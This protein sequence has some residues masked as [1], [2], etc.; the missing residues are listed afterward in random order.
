MPASQPAYFHLQEFS[1]GGVLL[2][3][4]RLY[5]YAQGTTALKT[6]YTDPAGAV[7]QTYTADGLGG[8]YIALNARGE[9]PA[10]LYLA[11]GSYDIALKRPDGSTVWTR[12]A[13]PTVD[14]AALSSD[15]GTA[16]ISGTWFGNVVASLA[17]LGTLLGASLIGFIQAGIGAVLRSCQSKLRERI[18]VADFGA[19]GDGVADDTIAINAALV[20]AKGK[21]LEFGA[22]LTYK[23]TSSLL[24]AGSNTGIDGKGATIDST[25]TGA[26]FDNILTNG[27]GY[28]NNIRMRDLYIN[29]RTAGAFG[30]KVRNSYSIYERVGFALTLTNTSG[31]GF[32]LMGDPLGAGP[33][34]NKFSGCDVQS[35]S[36]GLDHIGVAFMQDPVTHRSPNANTWVGGRIGQC[37]TGFII[38][39]NGNTIYSPAIEGAGAGSPTAVAV[40][41]EGD[42]A[43]NCVQN[44][45]FAPYIESVATAF[46]FDVNSASCGV[47]GGFYTGITTFINDLG[48]LNYYLTDLV[49]WKTPTGLK[50]GP[51][52]ADPN[53][54]D[55]Y[56]EGTWNPAPSNITVNSGAPVWTGNYTRIGNL[57]SA[58]FKMA[59][60]NV[61]INAG[62]SQINL[63]FAAAQNEWGVFGNNLTTVLG[64]GVA[65]YAGQLY[66]TA[67]MTSSGIGGSITYRV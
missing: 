19:V 62:T 29:M 20:A 33:Y 45:V 51:V 31:R 21:T 40:K 67:A 13:D 59:G 39:G 36:L 11:P 1:D 55:Y 5:T 44:H 26:G 8:Q 3:G 37:L 28:L 41:F 7:P 64:G 42:T 24:I 46:S 12:R 15:T 38:K 32:A 16:K 6:A 17:A 58:T 49:P 2:L 27:T 53:A 61:T 66:F 60:G 14:A 30:I 35:Q 22:G 50:F 63:P 47:I 4:G 23:V 34:Y 52:V 54:L 9:L 18:S 56:G 43:A 25:A 10:P 65:T 48:S 57:V